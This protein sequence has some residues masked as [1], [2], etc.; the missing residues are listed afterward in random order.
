[1]MLASPI[2]WAFGVSAATLWST[3][4]LT[5]PAMLGVRR[6][7]GRRV[8]APFAR[9]RLERHLVLFAA[10]LGGIGA[11]LTS[12]AVAF[13]LYA[14]NSSET[15]SMLAA[16]IAPVPLAAVPWAAGELLSGASLRPIASFIA[17]AAVAA[18][19]SWIVYALL[20][21]GQPRA[22]LTASSVLMQLPALFLPA[23]LAARA[24][25]AVRGEPVSALP[26]EA[27]ALERL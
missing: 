7:V 2:E 20:W 25:L 12:D 14:G 10:L 4:L 11:I 21:S 26:P 27:L 6:L 3:A 5:I 8:A 24:Y 19:T 15:A 9:D 23:L 17:A 13:A 22:A 1:M 18:V 16:F